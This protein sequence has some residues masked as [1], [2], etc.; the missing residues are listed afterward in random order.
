VRLDDEAFGL[1]CGE[2]VANCGG[3]NREMSL[4]DD[5]ARADRLAGANVLL[6]EGAKD[7]R[8]AIFEHV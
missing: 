8:P 6:D 5:G 4:V 2:V 7:L 1:E 3:R